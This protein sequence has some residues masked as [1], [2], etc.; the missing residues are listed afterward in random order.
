MSMTDLFTIRIASDA[1]APIIVQ[2][3]RSMFE[4]M[5]YVDQSALD[6]MDHR[7]KPWVTSKL[8]HGEYRHWFALNESG[9]I[10][11][12]AGMWIMEWAPHPIDQSGQRGNVMNVYTRR[13]YRKRGLA[14]RLTAL[15]LDWCRAN[16]ISTVVLNASDAGRPIYE[17]LGFRATNEM[18]VQLASPG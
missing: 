13:E 14:K 1:D 11:A 15:I 6:R 17:S 3:R 16:G 10:V 2:Q 12:G 4:E 9:A 8:Q 5:G 18:R 7:F